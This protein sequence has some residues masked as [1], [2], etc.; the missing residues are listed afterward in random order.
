VRIE[1]L[2]IRH[3]RNLQAVDLALDPGINYFFGENGAGK[4]AILEAVALLARGRSFRP[5]QP[6]ELISFGA[7]AYLVRARLRDELR[8]EQTVG[9]SRERGGRVEIRVNG[10]PG[11]RLSDMARLLPAQI[12]L[13]SLGDIVFG[14]PSERRQWLDW[15]LF[16]VKPSYLQGLRQYLQLLR[17][18]NAALRSVASGQLREDA[19][20]VWTD[21]LVGQ[22]ELVDA[23][24]SEYVDAVVKE[25][26]EFLAELSPGLAVRFRYR[27]GWNREESLAKV[28]SESLPR[29]VKS[30]STSAGPHRSDLEIMVGGESAGGRAASVLSR[31]QGKIVASAMVLAQAK[32]LEKVG[33]RSSVFLID[34]LGAEL[35][36]DH[37]RRLF[38]ALGGMECQVLATSTQAPE[39]VETTAGAP[40]SR[41]HVKHGA[42]Q[43]VDAG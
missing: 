33:R 14:G 37:C 5:G 32:L 43:R 24:R 28:L 23:W 16:H 25:V 39:W 15:G 7:S 20:S 36:Q 30:G 3:L 12:V 1:T 10:D 38:L 6:A 34:D 17:Q 29:D 4:T 13:P 19:L 35:D 21:R 42:V 8:G 41:F 40:I 22:A 2:E 11:N 9:L 27:R 31:G 26:N 18:R